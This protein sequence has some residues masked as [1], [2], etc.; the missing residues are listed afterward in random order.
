MGTLII[1]M[2]ISREAAQSWSIRSDSNITPHE[3]DDCDQDGKDGHN[4]GWK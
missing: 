4:F 3:D 2:Q 1:S